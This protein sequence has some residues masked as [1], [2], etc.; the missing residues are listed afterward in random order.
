MLHRTRVLR[1]GLMLVL[2]LVLEASD[3]GHAGGSID[4]RAG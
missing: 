3:G 1:V 2:V 4:Q